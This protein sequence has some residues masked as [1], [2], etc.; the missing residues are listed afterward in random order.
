[1]CS[2]TSN[3]DAV[4]PH[5][6]SVKKL[7]ASQTLP[8]KT[9]LLTIDPYTEDRQSLLEILGDGQWNI[10]GAS[11]LRE[12]TIIMSQSLPDIVLC[13]RELPDGS[14]KDVFREPEGLSRPAVVVVSRNA[15]ER[16][17]AEVLNLGAY[18]LLLKP[19]DA[20]EVRRVVRGA[21]RISAQAAGV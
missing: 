4:A 11:S 7:P 2:V 12:A 21:C 10:L 3:A 20:A 16:L 8:E 9:T 6:P 1:M 19:Y 18:D 17:W 15:D 5:F 13:E 14:W